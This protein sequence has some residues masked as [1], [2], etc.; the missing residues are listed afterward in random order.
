MIALGGAGRYLIVDQPEKATLSLLSQE[1]VMIAD[2][3]GHSNFY[4]MMSAHACG[5]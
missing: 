3:T 4:T 2:F 5:C 1:A